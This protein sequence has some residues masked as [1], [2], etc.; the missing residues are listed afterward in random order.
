VQL[1]VPAGQQDLAELLIKGAHW[2][3]MD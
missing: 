3:Q 2:F 1:P